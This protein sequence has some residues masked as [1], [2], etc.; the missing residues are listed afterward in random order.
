MAICPEADD[1]W[2]RN[3]TGLAITCSNYHRQVLHDRLAWAPAGGSL[4]YC[5]RADIGSSTVPTQRGPPR[6]R[7]TVRQG[8]SA[9]LP[10]PSRPRWK[11]RRRG[12]AVGWACTGGIHPPGRHGN[13]FCGL[14]GGAGH[15]IIPIDS[16]MGL[17][18][19]VQGPSRP[20]WKRRRRGSPSR[21]TCVE[22]VCR[23]GAYIN[24][25]VARTGLQ[26]LHIPYR[27][28]MRKVPF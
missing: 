17:G 21:Y 1:G 25:P 14:W 5:P 20:R 18:G 6:P 12:T 15:N 28:V 22:G 27:L 26:S 2:P 3:S 4:D 10:G 16:R 24:G 13:G 19:A 7:R 11:G 9:G 23:P 8:R